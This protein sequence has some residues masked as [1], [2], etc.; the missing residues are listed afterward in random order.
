MLLMMIISGTRL[1]YDRLQH[2]QPLVRVFGAILLSPFI[3]FASVV[4][5]ISIII[6]VV[7]IKKNRRYESDV[8]YMRKLRFFSRGFGH[9]LIQFLF[10][11]NPFFTNL[12]GILM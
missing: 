11:T 12:A 2:L 7:G 4:D 3:H 8:E 9:L 6:K 10:V 5:N 1:A